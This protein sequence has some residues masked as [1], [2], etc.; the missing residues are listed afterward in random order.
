MDLAAV[1]AASDELASV[2]ERQGLPAIPPADLSLP[3]LR[4][5]LRSP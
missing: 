4:A 5:D 3:L 2:I 1:L